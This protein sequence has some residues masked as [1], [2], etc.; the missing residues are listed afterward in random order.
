[1]FVHYADA[2]LVA[3]FCHRKSKSV[4]NHVVINYEKVY[5]T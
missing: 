1:M 5:I 3:N 2:F 4:I